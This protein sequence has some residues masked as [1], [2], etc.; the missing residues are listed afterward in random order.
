[1]FYRIMNVFIGLVITTLLASCSSGTQVAEGGIGG[2]GIS[3]GTV[4]GFGSIVVNGV[5][6]DTTGAVVYKDDDTPVTNMNDADIN[7]LISLGMTVTIEGTFNEDGT[8]GTA[9]TITYEDI[10]E[11][12]VV[13]TPSGSTFNVLGQ[14]VNVVDGVTQYG[15][16]E[17]Y[18][19]CTF[20]GFSDLADRKVVEV[21]GFINENGEI[22]A[23][24]IEIQK[25]N[26]TNNVDVFEI[27]GTTS[28]IDF[29]NFF[30]GGL[31]VT[32]AYSTNAFDGQFVEAKGMFNPL[33]T[34]LIASEVDL[35]NE[36]FDDDNVA[37]EGYKIE[38]EGIIVSSGCNVALP[39]TFTLGGVTVLAEVD[40]VYSGDAGPYS[41]LDISVGSKVEVE[42]TLQGGILHASEIG[43]E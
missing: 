17:S 29:D 6:F 20:S 1:M 25:D 35:K 38:L 9:S 3:T 22:I 24:Y 41:V 26:Y 43:F 4:T 30:I 7:Q 33:S 10:L 2:T 21:S 36:S 18:I 34:T 5:H 19:P 8:T 12:P 28:P 37:Y 31:T 13:G 23:G 39:C 14:T 16:D 42:G 27:K 11:G 15:C 32:H 40:T